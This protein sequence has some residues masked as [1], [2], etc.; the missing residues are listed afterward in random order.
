MDMRKGRIILPAADN[1]GGSA[2]SDSILSQL[3]SEQAGGQQSRIGQRAFNHKFFFTGRDGSAQY[4]P[5]AARRGKDICLVAASFW[6]GCETVFKLQTFYL[7]FGTQD[8]YRIARFLA[9][10]KYQTIHIFIYAQSVRP[11]A[12]VVSQILPEP[13]TLH[14]PALYE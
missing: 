1:F 9:R 2:A 12:V 11:C 5:V 4:S 14:R 10:P 6:A 13:F 3:L 8:S 7:R